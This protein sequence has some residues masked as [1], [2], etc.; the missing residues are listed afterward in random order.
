MTIDCT[1]GAG[2]YSDGHPTTEHAEGTRYCETCG[3]TYS[4]QMAVCDWQLWVCSCTPAQCAD[5]A[6]L[7]ACYHGDGHQ[8][9]DHAYAYETCQETDCDRTI[10]VI[11]AEC[12]AEYG[13]D[14][15]CDSSRY[16]CPD[17]EAA[18]PKMR[19]GKNLLSPR[20]I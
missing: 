1:H 4:V 15:T 18:Q 8:C 2:H 9:E 6:A 19:P 3:R 12:D 20:R 14:W 13:G 10:A 7:D 11:V 5:C 16:S 17:C